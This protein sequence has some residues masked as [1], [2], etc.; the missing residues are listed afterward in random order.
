[1]SGAVQKKRPARAHSDGRQV[2]VML[3]TGRAPADFTLGGIRYPGFET[4]V[5]EIIWANPEVGALAKKAEIEIGEDGV[6]LRSGAPRVQK[7][8]SQNASDWGQQ[9][10]AGQRIEFR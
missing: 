9:L 2:G 10:V 7:T 8:M 4:T 3:S 1:M 6:R 5:A